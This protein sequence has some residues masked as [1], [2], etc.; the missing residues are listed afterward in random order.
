MNEIDFSVDEKT[1]EEAIEAINIMT[2]DM[3][4]YDSLDENTQDNKNTCG[5]QWVRMW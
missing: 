5:I 2:I 1:Q 4:A 3:K